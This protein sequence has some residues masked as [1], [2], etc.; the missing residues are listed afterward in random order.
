MTKR[1]KVGLAVLTLLFVLFAA[2]L[3]WTVRP[4]GS[5]SGDPAESFFVQQRIRNLEKGN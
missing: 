3:A 4:V 1:D 5:G 2:L